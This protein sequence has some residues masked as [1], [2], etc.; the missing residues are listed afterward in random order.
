MEIRVKKIDEI[1]NIDEL[2]DESING[3]AFCYKYFLKLK[4]VEKIL[5]VYHGE[6][7]IAL[8]PLFT[9]GNSL[10]QSTMYV[11]YGGPIFL[12]KNF[13]YRKFIL[14]TRNIIFEITNYLKNN[15]D[16][17]CFSLDPVIT[18]IIPCV[19][20][21]FVPEVRYTY[22]IDLRNSIEEIYNA[23]GSDRKDNIKSMQDVE[24]ILD[25][26][27]EYF[28][29]DEALKWEYNYGDEIS[30]TFVKEYLKE[31]IALDRGKCF[32]A[33]KNKKV[34]GAVAVVWD[35][36]NCY[37]MYSYYDKKEKTVIPLLYYEMIKYLKSNN[38]CDYLD[39]EG[40]V[41][42]EIEEWNLSFG[43]RQVI[44]FNLYY[45]KDKKEE[46]Y[47]ELYDYGEKNEKQF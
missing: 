33:K 22:K 3:S 38:I 4:S 41:F 9:D 7:L 28:D 43:A 45:E 21:D 11:P 44:Y 42:R 47:S 34:L 26:E 25:D 10:N 30:S 20:N 8:M 24:V 31:S 46:L 29:F 16:S 5:C 40:S 19:K 27:L 15:Y 17:V 1:S 23:F 39:F 35:K 2:V 32:M 36:K 37:I 6:K 13:S 12:Y 14:Y 18:D